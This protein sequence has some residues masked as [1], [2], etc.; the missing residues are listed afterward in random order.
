VV[1]DLLDVVDR[2]YRDSDGTMAVP[3]ENLDVVVIRA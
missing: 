2:H 3:A 1:G